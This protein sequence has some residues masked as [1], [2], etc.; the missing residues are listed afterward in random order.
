MKQFLL[1]SV[2]YFA[3]AS[4]ATCTPLKP[5]NRKPTDPF[6]LQDDKLHNGKSVFNG[7]ANFPVYRNVKAY[8]AKG[9]GVTDD[10]AAINAAITDGGRCGVGCDSS[11]LSPA[12]VFFPQGKYLISSPIIQYYFTQLVGDAVDPPTLVASPNFKLSYMIQSDPYATTG[13]NWWTNQNNFFRQVRNFVLDMTQAPDSLAV[14]GIHWQVAQATSISNVKF[15]MSQNAGNAHQGIWMENGSGGFMSDL[16]FYGG[17]FGMWVGNQQFTSSNLTFHN[18]E[19]AIFVNWDW[20]W[21]F[22]G[23]SINNCGVGLDL[24]T[25]AKEQL[26]GSI[27]LMD[28]DINNTPIGVKTSTTSTSKPHASGTVTIDNVKLTNVQIA[29]ADLQGNAIVK[30]GSLTIDSWGQGQLYKT[31]GAAGTFFQDNFPAKPTKPQ[32]LLDSAG[33]YFE[34]KRPQ[35]EEYGIDDVINVKTE[36]AAGDGKTDDTAVLTKILAQYADCKILYFPAGTYVLKSTLYVPAGSRLVGQTWSILQGEGSFFSDFRNPQP[37][38]QVGKEGESGVAELTDLLFSTGEGTAGAVLVQ[39]NIRDPAGQQ[40]V[41]GMWD[42]HFRV[43]AAANTGMGRTQCPSLA[44]PSPQ[45]MGASMLLHLTKTSSAHLQ[46]VWAWT[47][48]HDLDGNGQTS[49]FSGR[50]ILIESEQGPVW[51]YGTASEHNV[52]Y[53][54]RLANARNV[55]A[56]MIQTE[57]P[58]YQGSPQAPAPFEFNSNLNDPKFNCNPAD[59][60]CGYAWGLSIYNSS[61]VYVY[62]AGLYNFYNNYNQTCLDTEDCQ[63]SMVSIETPRHTKSHIWIYNLNTKAAT[64]MV[65]SNGK[66]SI[67]QKDNRSTF[68]STIV[69]DLSYAV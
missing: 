10:T 31:A 40:G 14:V 67:F 9:D 4:A 60:G 32:V 35:Y 61:Q 50:G 41:A 26:A 27:L 55:M 18:A 13:L 51:L 2:I 53:Q 25:S 7:N 42:C 69:A 37:V 1:I 29:V 30:G 15:L 38:V 33:R 68:C 64:N 22:R 65:V 63:N 44:A 12:L 3:V 57:S 56:A 8:G 16:V 6:W 23:I 21:T 47:G 19:T 48:D 5:G 62:G 24:S 66:P 28:S 52:M 36:G 20:G 34:R 43:G 45:C 39:W 11:T 59:Q 58:Y 17:K 54:Y 46:N 49:V